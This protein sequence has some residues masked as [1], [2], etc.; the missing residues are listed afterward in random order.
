VV[1]VLAPVIRH[2]QGRLRLLVD[3]L[4]ALVVSAALAIGVGALSGTTLDEAV[5][6]LA[7]AEPPPVYPADWLAWPP[8][9]S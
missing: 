3:Y 4:L 2:G 5:A 9:S 6:G 1:L 7:S 8:P